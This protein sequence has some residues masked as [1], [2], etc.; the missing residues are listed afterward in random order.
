MIPHPP[1]L[2]TKVKN[3]SPLGDLSIF[4]HSLHSP[5]TRDSPV[6][7]IQ[8]TMGSTAPRNDRIPNPLIV[9]EILGIAH[10]VNI[11]DCLLN[12]N[13]TELRRSDPNQ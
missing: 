4:H 7:R 11:Y 3:K 6:L 8:F 12:G 1:I 13:Q 10:D 5:S 2:V 9:L